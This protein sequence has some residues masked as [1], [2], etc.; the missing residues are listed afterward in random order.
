ML[1]AALILG[2]LGSVPGLIIGAIVMVV[3]PEILRFPDYSNYLFLAT[4]LIGSIVLV[5]SWKLV[6]AVFAATIAVGFVANAIFLVA[7]V[8]YLPIDEW[9][10]GPLAPILGTWIFHA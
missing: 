1:Y 7:G 5:K 10:E 4:V 9:I 2:G 3:L 6:V 8:P